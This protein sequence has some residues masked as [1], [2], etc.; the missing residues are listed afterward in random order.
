MK[1]VIVCGDRHGCFSDWLPLM[2]RELN[3]FRDGEHCL[4][5]HGDQHGVDKIASYLCRSD[6][7]HFA[8][9]R[10][11]I[12]KDWWRSKGSSAGPER[13]QRMS[14][15]LNS[16][17]DAGFYVMVLAFHSNYR[18]KSRGTRNMLTIAKKVGLPYELFE[19][20]HVTRQL[21]QLELAGIGARSVALANSGIAGGDSGPTF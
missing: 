18:E 8:E 5:L 19:S 4:V 13:N 21:A 2:R 3:A 1:A 7:D 16:Y 14:N 6:P 11:P 12:S 9:S 10:F 17:A 20:T 15:V